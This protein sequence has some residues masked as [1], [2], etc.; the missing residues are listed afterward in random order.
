MS[1]R[2]N[3]KYSPSQYA[4]LSV[5]GTLAGCTVGV[6]PYCA[7]LPLR[8]WYMAAAYALSPRQALARCGGS[9]GFGGAGVDGA[10]SGG[11]GPPG[12]PCC[13]DTTRP[14][15]SFVCRPIEEDMAD[16]L[17]FG[18]GRAVCA[19]GRR[20]ERARARGAAGVGSDA[21]TALEGW[22]EGGAGGTCGGGGL[23]RTRSAEKEW[24]NEFLWTPSR[25]F[26]FPPEKGALGTAEP[27]TPAELV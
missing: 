12:W 11:E 22:C 20:G 7:S 6:E 25:R 4:V 16:E 21:W 26:R 10:G 27:G 23:V 18:A 1:P 8:G 24:E 9:Y 13:G 2:L 14:R 5:N 3:T 19:M 17:V 15:G